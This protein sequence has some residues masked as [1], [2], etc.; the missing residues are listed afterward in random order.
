[1]KLATLCLIFGIGWSCDLYDDYQWIYRHFLVSGLVSTCVKLQGL[2]LSHSPGEEMDSCFLSLSL[3]CISAQF[4][5]LLKALHMGFPQNI[6]EHPRTSQNC[7]GPRCKQLIT[8][9][10]RMMRWIANSSW[11]STWQFWAGRGRSMK[12]T[13]AQMWMCDWRYG[14]GHV[15]LGYQWTEHLTSF[16]YN[17]HV[18]G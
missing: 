10:Q 9:V 7:L 11:T 4:F 18:E 8:N 14:V 3:S 15:P 13:A 12:H 2:R 1:M 16:I 17:P 5:T 6:P